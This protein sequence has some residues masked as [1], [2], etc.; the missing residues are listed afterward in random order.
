MFLGLCAVSFV[1]NMAGKSNAGMILTLSWSKPLK[2][3]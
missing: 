2:F 1:K 3:N